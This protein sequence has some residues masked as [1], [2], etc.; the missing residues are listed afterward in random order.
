[1]RKFLWGFMFLEKITIQ[2]FKRIKKK[3]TFDLAPITILV[4]PNSSGKS[5]LLEAINLFDHLTD[6]V[7]NDNSSSQDFLDDLR[8]AEILSASSK[9]KKISIECNFSRYIS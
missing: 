6:Y 1:M 9:I 7:F 8:F 3:T 5:S 2:N 4:G